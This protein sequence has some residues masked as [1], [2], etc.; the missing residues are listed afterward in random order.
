MLF[1]FSKR[2]REKQN[3]QQS[4]LSTRRDTKRESERDTKNKILGHATQMTLKQV[5]IKKLPIKSFKFTGWS[6]C[7]FAREGGEVSCCV[8]QIRVR[9]NVLGPFGACR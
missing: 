6:G 5:K 9:N 7:R 2:E 3:K 8:G 1:D 4:F